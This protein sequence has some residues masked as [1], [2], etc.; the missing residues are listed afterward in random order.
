[1]ENPTQ[2]NKDILSKELLNTDVLIT[3]SFP[4]LSR[5]LKNRLS[6]F[7]GMR[8]R[9]K[10][11]NGKEAKTN[12]SVDY[13]IIKIYVKIEEAVCIVGKQIFVMLQKMKKFRSKH[14]KGVPFP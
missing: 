12:R 13:K 1:M 10:S 4:I 9:W 8:A 2:L 6:H 5:D 3:H 14:R 11:W 7:L